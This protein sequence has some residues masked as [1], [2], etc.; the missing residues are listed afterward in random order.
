MLHISNFTRN[1]VPPPENWL[2]RRQELAA[3]SHPLTAHYPLRVPSQTLIP[4]RQKSPSPATPI[5]PPSQLRRAQTPPSTPPSSS[6]SSP[7]SGVA[8]ARAAWMARNAAVRAKT[9]V[10][11]RKSRKSRKT[12][13]S[14]R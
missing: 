14:R 12:R 13:K 7:L 8:A 3:A 10:G 4:I 6:N 2:R 5:T 1:N 11:G 9:K